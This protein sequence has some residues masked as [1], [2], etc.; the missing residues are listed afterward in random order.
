MENL[1]QKELHGGHRCEHAVTPPRIPN[2]LTHGEDG[3][4][5]QQRGPFPGQALKDGG[6]T[7]DHGGTSYTIGF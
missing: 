4:G 5:L 7:R 1:Q 2:L 6:D 3:V